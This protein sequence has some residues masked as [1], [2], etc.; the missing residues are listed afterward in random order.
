M[1][2]GVIRFPGSASDDVEQAIRRFPGAEPVAISSR[3]ATLP[4]IDALILPGG[5]SYG[6]Y[7]RP[8][9]IAGV[10][11]VI[12]A[13][14]SFA[15]SGAPVLGIG[16]GFQIL[17]EVGILPGALLANRG[18]RAISG[19]ISIR[20]ERSAPPFTSRYR[21]GQLLALPVAHRSGC[22]FAPAEVL[23]RLEGEGQVL[24]RYVDRSGTRSPA[25]NPNG[26]AREIAGIVNAAGNVL[27]MMP[28][29]ERAVD[30]EIGSADGVGL[31][32]SLLASIA[33]RVD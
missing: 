7:L 24:F 3:E 21:A 14:R 25:A 30:G 10:A 31:F 15:E 33:E 23:D 26:S 5:F 17:C 16:N 29:P 13:V 6:D 1:R 11:P 19:T 4:G 18:V 2:I 20:V 22:Y 12:E 27:G 9:A 28:H 32:E 8:G